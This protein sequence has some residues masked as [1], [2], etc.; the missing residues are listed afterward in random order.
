MIEPYKRRDWLMGAVTKRLR[1]EFA[2][3]QVGRSIE[4][5]LALTGSDVPSLMHY[6]LELVQLAP[7]T[8]SFA[9]LLPE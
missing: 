1:E 5:G 7:T 4:G 8:W 3:P 9:N 2:K 6:S